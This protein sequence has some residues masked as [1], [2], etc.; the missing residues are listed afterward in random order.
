[1]I[2]AILLPSFNKVL[3]GTMK[4][5]LFWGTKGLNCLYLLHNVIQVCIC[6]VGVNLHIGSIFKTNYDRSMTGKSVIATV[7]YLCFLSCDRMCLYLLFVPNKAYFCFC[8]FSNFYQGSDIRT[9][10]QP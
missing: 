1:M 8:N 3:D 4:N 9:V 5:I 2:I 10:E 6:T 7:Q